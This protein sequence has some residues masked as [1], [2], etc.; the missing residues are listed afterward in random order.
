[1]IP[2][3]LQQIITEF[4][5]LETD[6]EK[7]EVLM[8]YGEKLKPIKSNEKNNSN[9]VQGCMSI[10]YITAKIKN[11]KIFFEGEADS[12]LIK[13]LVQ[14]LIEGINEIRTKEFLEMKE[15]FLKIFGLTNSLTSSR[16]NASKNIFLKMK[17]QVRK[18]INNNTN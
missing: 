6:E 9:L 15:D 3:K 18:E 11:D 10:V 16:A 12:L 1:M 2:E 13:G 5:Q 14:I 4:E 7:F 17:E 8:E